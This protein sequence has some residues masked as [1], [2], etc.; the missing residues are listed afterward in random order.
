LISSILVP[1]LQGL[2]AVSIFFHREPGPYVVGL[3]LLLVIAGL[4][5]AL[6][7]LRPLT[8]HRAHAHQ[9][10]EGDLVVDR[11]DV[12]EKPDLAEQA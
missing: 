9:A 11:H 3:V 5:F 12:A 10:A 2:N 7:V 4:Q 8:A 6:L 1:T